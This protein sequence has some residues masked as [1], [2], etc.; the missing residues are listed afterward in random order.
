MLA[1]L[2]IL[3]MALGLA[4]VSLGVESDQIPFLFA[5]G[6]I[7]FLVVL[8]VSGLLVTSAKAADRIGWLYLIILALGSAALGAARVLNSEG[9]ITIAAS[10]QLGYALVFGTVAIVQLFKKSP[11]TVD[12]PH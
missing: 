4:S 5:V 12:L 3:G 10:F 1:M 9:D 7:S 2:T 6:I 11:S 8:V